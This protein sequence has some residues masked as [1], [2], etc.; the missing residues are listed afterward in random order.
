MWMG[1]FL[2]QDDEFFA[3]TLA[4]MCDLVHCTFLMLYK[5]SVSCCTNGQSHVVHMGKCKAEAE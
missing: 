1:N 4:D 5:W 2:G 3:D